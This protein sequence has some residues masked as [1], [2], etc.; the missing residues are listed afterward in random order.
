MKGV[1]SFS[2]GGGSWFL[3]IEGKERGP[4]AEERVIEML[5]NGE[6]DGD[7][8]VWSQGM[9]DWV[10]ARQVGTFRRFG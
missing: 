8:Y 1:A 10:R 6:I 5:E 3:V 7:T 4:L 9:A 2:R